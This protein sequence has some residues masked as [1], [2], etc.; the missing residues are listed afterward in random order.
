MHVIEPYNTGIACKRHHVAV[1]GTFN[2][3]LFRT[4]ICVVW[5]KYSPL[6]L[7]YLVKCVVSSTASDWENIFQVGHQG[8]YSRMVYDSALRFR[9]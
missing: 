8:W 1:K 2:N 3:S 7:V 4:K 9:L 5:W 6:R